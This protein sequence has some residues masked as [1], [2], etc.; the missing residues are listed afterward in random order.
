MTDIVPP[1][2][3]E[4]LPILPDLPEIPDITPAPRSPPP[5]LNGG[6]AAKQFRNWC[7]TINILDH[8]DQDLWEQA[9]K[10]NIMLKGDNPKIKYLVWE[11]EKGDALERP[12]I[13]GYLEY[14][15][16]TTLA[17]LK[18]LFNLNYIHAEA[19]MGTA[20]EAANYCKKEGSYF[21]FGKISEDRLIRGR[22][23]GGQQVKKDWE[24]MLS[25]IKAGTEICDFIERYPKYAMTSTSA[26]MK[27]YAIY[28]GK[29]EIPTLDGE[30]KDYNLWIYGEAGTGKSRFAFETFGSYYSKQP[31]KWWDGY[32][33]EETV[34]LDDLDPESTKYIIRY[35]KI[36][37]DRYPFEAEIKGG[38]LKIRPRRFVIT[39][40]YSLEEC[41]SNFTD[42]APLRRRFKVMEFTMT[43]RREI[44]EPPRPLARCSNFN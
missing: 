2:S 6:R 35:L 24:E 29:K 22:A 10:Q 14:Q 30:L 36:W 21:E 31:S 44:L 40:N 38:T 17:G 4:D 28:E 3:F 23:N 15:T 5:L 26:M 8:E 7:F 9:M 43:E 27:I 13:Q 41:I 34:V 37:S 25:A 16:K 42:I 11:F 19:R 12:H 20:S 18:R 33:G 39:S 1:P 32:K